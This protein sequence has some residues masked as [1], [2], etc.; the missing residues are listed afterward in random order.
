MSLN[1]IFPAIAGFKGIWVKKQHCKARFRKILLL[2]V[3]RL[4]R[5]GTMDGGSDWGRAGRLEDD[6]P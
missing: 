2:V 5:W 6:R 4:V 3:N 1:I